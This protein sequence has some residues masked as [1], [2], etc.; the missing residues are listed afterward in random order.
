MISVISA[1]A[2]GVIV[3][4]IG[5]IVAIVVGLVALKTAKAAEKQAAAAAKQ[6]DVAE[7]EYQRATVPRLRIARFANSNAD[8]TGHHRQA[9][10]GEPALETVYIKFDNVREATAIISRAMLGSQEGELTNA[11]CEPGRPGIANFVADPQWQVGSKVPL[12]VVYRALDGG[13]AGRLDGELE[14]IDDGWRIV[15]DADGR[16]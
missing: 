10:D 14:R 16:V 8:V 2:I 7:R 5:V 11:N 13:Q 1:T 15:R 4:G 3:T 12:D 9:R 6:A